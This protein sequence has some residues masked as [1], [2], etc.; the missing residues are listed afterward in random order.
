MSCRNLIDPMQM[1][2]RW[3]DSYPKQDLDKNYLGDVLPLCSERPQNSFLMQGARYEFLSSYSGYALQ[4]SATSP[5]YK[6]LCGAESGDSCFKH[7]Y[8][9]F[10]LG[11]FGW[12]RVASAI[13]A[14]DG[15]QQG[16]L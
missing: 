7:A 12:F 13:V 6:A 15:S 2:E 10:L 9:P 16:E 5:L 8:P 14:T 3:H 1:I 4:I 11:C